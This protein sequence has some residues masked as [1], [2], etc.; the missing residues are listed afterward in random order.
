MYIPL[1]I[2]HWQELSQIAIPRSKSLVSRSEAM[3]T[4]LRLWFLDVQTQGG[5]GEGR[6][7]ARQGKMGSSEMLSFT[8]Q[9]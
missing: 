7:V 8:S 3:D 4:A 1:L 6:T 2:A 9:S 5:D